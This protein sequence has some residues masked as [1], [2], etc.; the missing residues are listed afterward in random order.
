ME[1]SLTVQLAPIGVV[2]CAQTHA[3]DHGWGKVASEIQLDPVYRGGL[4]GLEQFSHAVIVFYLHAV[5]FQ[6]HRDLMRRP[7]GRSDMP[8]LGIF[9]Q[10]AACRPSRLGITTVRIVSVGE[11]SLRVSGL[12][13]IDGTPV[14]DIKPH[15]AIFDAPADA[16]P[17]PPWFNE[18]MKGYF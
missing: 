18:L 5:D 3:I 15:A 12:D 11:T 8:E 10:R 14:L 9:A 6:F 2:R 1:N 13:A 17:P 7:R 16:D 4:H